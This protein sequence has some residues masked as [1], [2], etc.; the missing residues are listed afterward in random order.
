M[1]KISGRSWQYLSVKICMTGQLGCFTVVNTLIPII[2]AR[3]CLDAESETMAC[4]PYLPCHDES[5]R[6]SH[7]VDCYVPKTLREHGSRGCW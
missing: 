1:V 7:N 3:I 4:G 6:N 5:T 2:I